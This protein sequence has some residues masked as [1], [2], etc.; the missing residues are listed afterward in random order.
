M[1]TLT[2]IRQYNALL[3]TVKS[4]H[5]TAPM[6]SNCYITADTA[7]HRIQKNQLSVITFSN[8]LL[9]LID[10]GA[11]FK[12]QIW[13]TEPAPV[14]V[15]RVNKPLVMDLVFRQGGPTEEQKQVEDLLVMAGM[16]FHR[17][18]REFLIGHI[19]SAERVRCEQKMDFLLRQGFRFQP[20]AVWQA[21]SAYELLCRNI[22]RYVLSSF[23]EM[24]WP[25][26]C[27]KGQAFCA[28]TPK[29]EIGAVCVVPRGF[30]GGLVAVDL[31]YRGQGIGRAITYYS[32]YIQDKASA[33]DRLWIASDNFVNLHLTQAIGGKASLRRARSYIMDP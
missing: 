11:F 4:V 9:F 13:L 18:A 21:L 28:I 29:G 5:K 26:L 27:E 16:R 12:Q 32:Y 10:Q 17:E 7:E 14:P 1:E 30:S 8:G 23:Q 25:S 15:P 31:E 24:D 20:V 22:D 6:Y 2:N 3:N 19:S 33:V